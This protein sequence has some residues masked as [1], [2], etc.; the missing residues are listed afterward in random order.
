[1]KGDVILVTGCSEGGIGYALC[2]AFA[3]KQCRVFA[4]AR[5][6]EAM[7]GLLGTLKATRRPRSSR[8]MLDIVEGGMTW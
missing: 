6:L 7:E 8:C 4:S 2:K 1:M 3:S 5:R